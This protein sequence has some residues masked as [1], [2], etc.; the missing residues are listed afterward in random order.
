MSW[1]H[2][3]AAIVKNLRGVIYTSLDWEKLHGKLKWLKRHFRYRNIG[4]TREILARYPDLKVYLRAPL[5][6]LNYP[7]KQAEELITVYQRFLNLPLL[8][9]ETYCMASMYVAPMIVLGE[10]SIEDLK[11][12]TVATVRTSKKL[13]DK[14]YK[15]HMRI[16]D[17]TTLDFYNWATEGAKKA[18]ET[19]LEDGNWKEI[20]NKRLTKIEEDK[21]RYWRISSQDGREIVL[22]LDL[23]PVFLRGINK[24][25]IESI[26]RKFR[27]ILPATLAIISAIVI[28]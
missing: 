23:L 11:Q 3:Y 8:V 2:L 17:Y 22:Y 20:L 25:N 13:D 6:E 5:I 28:V 9:I 14:D 21:K 10:K 27:E 1:F 12:L 4:V 16:V 7:V 18:I 26:Y 19:F 24:E 15:L